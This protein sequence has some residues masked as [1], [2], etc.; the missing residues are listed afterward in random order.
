M[1]VYHGSDICIVRHQAYRGARLLCY[2]EVCKW[3]YLKKGTSRVPRYR[4]VAL[5]GGG[6]CGTGR[7]K[8][9]QET[10]RK[11]SLDAESFQ[12]L[13]AAAFILQSRLDWISREPIRTTEAKRFAP[14]AIAQKRTPSI[15]PSLPRKGAL[16]E[17]NV[18]S[19]RMFWKGAEALAIA[20]VFCL[21][22]GM[23][24]HHLL[25]YPG[26]TSSSGTVQRSD[27]P[28]PQDLLSSV[29][30]SSQ[31][32]ATEKQS[33]DDG[34]GK[35][36]AHDGDLVAHYRPRTAGLPGPLRRRLRNDDRHTGRRGRWR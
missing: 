33:Q 28:T 6:R 29:L 24:I 13:L 1:Q 16:G 22:M 9:N 12:R 31:Q 26:R 5:K 11:P 14:R 27:M 35:V 7:E 25:A 19:K 15:R 18:V 23:S 17:A 34:D 8:M 30:A 10:Y 36:D 21:M 3:I 32:P 2:G 4:E 20:I